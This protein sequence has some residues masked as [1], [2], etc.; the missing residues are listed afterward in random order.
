[1]VTENPELGEGVVAAV[2]QRGYRKG[3]KVIRFA[4]VSVTN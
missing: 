2:F 4:M 1:M 3:D